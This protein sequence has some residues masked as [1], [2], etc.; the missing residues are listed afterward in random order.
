[1]IFRVADLRRVGGMRYNFDTELPTLLDI[2]AVDGPL[3][4]PV[5]TPAP[6]W[7]NMTANLITGEGKKIHQRHPASALKIITIT[8]LSLGGKGYP[9]SS[10]FHSAHKTLSEEKYDSSHSGENGPNL[11]VQSWYLKI[12]HSGKRKAIYRNSDK[13]ILNMMW[14]ICL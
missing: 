3:P 12:S 2:E 6:R 13:I 7:Q 4:I 14:M 10:W 8:L 9:S 11:F 1:M 5:P